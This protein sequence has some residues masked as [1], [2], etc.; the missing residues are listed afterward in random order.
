MSVTFDY[1]NLRHST[2]IYDILRQ[3]T[4]TYDNLRHSTTFYD[5]LRHST[6]S[7]RHS[8]TTYDTSTTFYGTHVCGICAASLRLLER[9]RSYRWAGNKLSR[10]DTIGGTLVG[11]NKRSF[12]SE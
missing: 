2:T 7:L 6:T 11:Q 1:D 8:T 5:N 10:Q 12:R 4:T 9:V 3:P